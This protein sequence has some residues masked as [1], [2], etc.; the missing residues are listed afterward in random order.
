MKYAIILNPVSGNG[1]SLRILP[2]IIDWAEKRN[3]ADV[4]DFE[5]F[6][7]IAPGDGIKLARIC[8][9]RRFGKVIVVGGDG[10]VNEVG[11]ELVGSETVMGVI[12]GG[13]GNDFYKMLG[14]DGRLIGGFETAFFGNPHDVDTGLINRRPF[15]NSVGIGFDAEVAVRASQAKSLSGMPVYLSALLRSLR[16]L[17]A[18]EL[19]IEMDRIRIET[20][21]ILVCVGNGRSSGGGFY[22]TPHAS[23]DDGFFD[24]C[25]IEAMPKSKVLRYLPRTLNGSHVRLS[26]VRIYR[27]KNVA[28]S[29]N[30]EFPMH[31]DG[32]PVISVNGGVKSAEFEMD[33]RKLKVAVAG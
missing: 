13:S 5:L 22:L 6:M 26:G 33:P 2:K 9:F 29:S 11:S 27:S 28:I 23:F 14:N 32:E 1:R 31:I 25:I 24:I 7:T 15:F 20:K 21:A 8:R 18:I 17:H 3:S 12:P 10:T 19:Q 30:E 16:N 4:I